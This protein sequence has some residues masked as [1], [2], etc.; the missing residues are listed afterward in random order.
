[1][2]SAEVESTTDSGTVATRPADRFREYLQL[3]AKAT[4][5]RA[6]DVA[7]NQIDNIITA[8]EGDDIDAVWDADT[9]GTVAGK[10]IAGVELDIAG[11]EVAESDDKYDSPLGVFASIDATVL[12]KP[13]AKSPWNIG[14]R[15]IIN[16][17]APLVVA[18]LRALEA[19][20]A[21]PVQAFIQAIPARNGDVLKLRPVPKRA[22]TATADK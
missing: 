20:D 1:M 7:A 5:S 4:P 16:C 21:F 15:V 17:G 22:A 18:K 6:W 13:D 10:D 11:Y 14:D 19:H 8:A 12:S 9:G 2:T 3:R